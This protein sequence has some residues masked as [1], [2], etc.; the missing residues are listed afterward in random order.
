MS[1]RVR[2]V[3]IVLLVAAVG[4]VVAAVGVAATETLT[5]P[6]TQDDSQTIQVSNSTNYL[7]PAAEN[8]TKQG[9][10]T[11]GVDVA[12]A[13]AADRERLEGDHHRLSLDERLANATDTTTVA[14]ETLREIQADIATLD[15]TQ[16]QLFMDYSA[17][18][19][20]NE[21]LFREVARLSVA[22]EQYRELAAHAQGQSR[23]PEDSPLSTQYANLAAETV[24]L[25]QPIAERIESAVSG[26][27]DSVTVYVQ[28]A[29]EGLVLATVRADRY[30]RQATLHNNRDPEA[31]DM[32]VE[33]ELPA[34][35][36]ASERAKEL[37]PWA[38][39]G[40][41]SPPISGF[42]NSSV[43]LFNASHSHGSL[44]AYIDGGTTDAFHES[45][46]K[47]PGSVPVSGTFTNTSNDL[48]VIVQSTAP[49]G[50]MLVSIVGTTGDAP[51]EVEIRING[52]S[53][54]RLGVGEQL[55][56]VQPVGGF[57]IVV[58]AP[59]N[60]TVSVTVP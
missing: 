60:E 6:T 51:S 11:A 14:R 1:R 52:H 12:G 16:R 54:G 13:I 18:D 5:V 32:F 37:Y 19:I 49:T 45:Q 40:F 20:S 17:G 21:T 23:I 41:L 59:T 39:Q 28:S 30:F 44:Q 3:V 58:T 15:E 22:A 38:S 36:A 2:L 27:A 7:S 48:R 50:P 9:Y 33:D 47:E 56:T 42:G 35:Q 10:Q 24:L 53:V 55:W 8:V 46:V 26:T 43:Y 31:V 57:D 25:S 29:D 34:P 4:T